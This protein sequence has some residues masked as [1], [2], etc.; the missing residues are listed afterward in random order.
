MI[1]FWLRKLLGVIPVIIGVNI[2]TFALFFMVNTPDNMARKHLGNKHV[3]QA[4]ISEW[5]HQHGYDKPLFY[6]EEQSGFGCITSTL[7]WQENVKLL[8]FH[9]G[10]SDEG[11][12]ISSDIAQRMW[13]SLALAVPTLIIAMSINIM[14]ALLFALFRGTFFDR[15]GMALCVAMMSI[16]GL[17][18]II[19]GQ[20]II[21]KNW[22]WLPLSGYLQG[23]EAWRF[24]LLPVMV[25]VISGLG[26]GIRWYR[27]LFL[28]EMPRSYV[29]TTRAYGCSDWTILCRFVL[30]NALIPILTGVVVIIPSL[31]MGSLI[32]ESFF[33]IPGL[34]SYTID[35]IAQQ[36]FAI[37]RSM[38]FIGTLTY[39]AGLILTDFSYTLVDPRVRLAGDKS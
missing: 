4:A 18:Y 8:T 35:A 1:L 38:V 3:T 19:M 31:F 13:P 34:G 22:R 14:V 21:A 30:P 6:N 2:I 15:A 28:E 36:D 20:F 5:K 7:F 39:V 12:A 29:R 9:F 11:R 10:L 27:T 33:G 26:A 23:V 25:G 32:M 37:L 16:S 24:L 17:F